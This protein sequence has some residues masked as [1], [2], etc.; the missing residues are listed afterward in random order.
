MSHFFSPNLKLHRDSPAR[1]DDNDL[2]SPHRL[3]YQWQILPHIQIP[4]MRNFVFVI[5]IELGHKN[6]IM[7]HTKGQRA[8]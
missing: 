5:R 1:Q 7:T 8:V 6:E 3:K 4:R 2:T